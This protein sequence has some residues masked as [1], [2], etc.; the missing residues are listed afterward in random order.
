M[1]RP[2]LYSLLVA[3]A[4]PVAAQNP[5]SARP[6]APAAA[7]TPSVGVK[8]AFINS[9]AIL[10]ATPGYAQA[11]STF[12]KEVEGYRAEVQRLQAQL[13]SAVQAFD[14]QSIA[15]SPAAKQSK[16]HE[17][18]GMQQ[19]L[20]QRTNDLQTQAQQR[21]QDLLQ[22]I[23]SRVNAVIQGIRAEDNYAMIFDADATGSPLVAVDPALNI[24]QRVIQRLQQS[25]SPSPSK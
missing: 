8:F 5:P 3:A 7:P 19:R 1:I 2:V 14:Q 17:L 20:E 10:Q 4:L 13:D 24:T 11:E 16:Q 6:A 15:L 9:R 25:S 22:P 12:T 21:E 23:Q 18:Q